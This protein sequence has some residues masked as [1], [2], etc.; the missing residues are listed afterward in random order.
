MDAAFKNNYDRFTFTDKSFHN[1]KTSTVYYDIESSLDS[2]FQVK[3]VDLL[4]E[5]KINTKKFLFLSFKKEITEHYIFVRYQDRYYDNAIKT[6]KIFVLPEELNNANSVVEY[7][8]SLIVKKRQQAEQKKL[9]Q[10]RKQEEVVKSEQKRLEQCKYDL[11]VIDFETTGLKS[12]LD[13]FMTDGKYDEILSVSIIDQDGNVLL[14]S[15]CKP[16]NRKT[17]AKAQEIHGISPAMVKNQPSFEELF[18]TIKEILLKSKMITAYNIDFELKFLY[19]FDVVFGFPGEVKLRD[20]I[21]WGPDPMLMYCAYKGNERWQKLTAVAKH[22]KFNFEAHNSLED[23]KATLYCYK[24]L[25][26][27]ATENTDKDY[28]IK[29]GYIYDNGNK[30]KWL[31]LTTYKIADETLLK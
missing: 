8:N 18:P 29:Y 22:F 15:L 21:V 28:I 13:T 1:A 31:D 25:I 11:V 16:Q 20:S 4:Q 27:Y 17:W 14:D 26:E 19:G 10:L 9:E 24:K 6:V 3:S 2:Y 5:L 23:V 12:P 7:I 30:G